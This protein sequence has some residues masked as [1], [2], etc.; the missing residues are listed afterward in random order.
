[1]RI[2]SLAKPLTMQTMKIQL[3]LTGNE[4]MAGHIVDSNS[5]MIAD[6]LADYGY[7]I[8]KKV[9]VGD[10]LSVLAEEI[11]QLSRNADLLIVNGG[12]GPTVDDLT[13]QAL[14]MASG[15][16]IRE[17]PQATAH[18]QQ[19]C[20]ER[21]LPLN[22]ANLKQA[23]LPADATIIANPIG[24]AVGF[25]IEHNHCLIACTPGVPVE[26]RA[27]LNDSLVDIIRQRLPQPISPITRRLQTF[28]IGES[29]LQQMVTTTLPD[30]PQQV[31]LGFRAG[32]PLLEV[33][34]SCHDPDHH[35][36]LLQWQS[37]LERL[38]ENEF[39]GLDQASLAGSLV[40]QL[41]A[42]GQTVTP[43][44]SCTGGLIASMITEVAGASSVFQ[45]GLVTYSDKMKHRLLGVCPATLERH[46][47]VSEAVVIEMVKGA[48]SISDADYGIAVSGIAG[49][50]GGSE[51]KPV[52]TV[53]VAWGHKEN[54]HSRRMQIN[55][56]RKYF[57]RVVANRCLDLIRRELQGITAPPRYFRDSQGSS[58]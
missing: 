44:E 29:S 19:W 38:I 56:S 8:D 43:A 23:M 58:D 7:T 9:T 36:L 34:L 41:A 55:G 49:P 5:A 22:Q 28:G 35:E 3:L 30:W 2:Y 54:I 15:Q 45:A 18:L 11:D 46:G 1:M 10:D 24:S 33:K 32:F 48:I 17:H 13:A 21:K 20:S 42:T 57:Q 39:I 51:N 31:E 26:L 40:E 12:L 47:A 25:S 6:M 53:W 50:E 52:G 14:A 37:R 27:I 16:I 4:L